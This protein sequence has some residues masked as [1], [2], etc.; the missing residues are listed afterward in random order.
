MRLDSNYIF[1]FQCDKV[2][3]KADA[4]EE[5]RGK[6]NVCMAPCDVMKESDIVFNCVSDPETAK[7]VII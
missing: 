6:V 4:C 2:K 7:K 3:E 5:T 1:F